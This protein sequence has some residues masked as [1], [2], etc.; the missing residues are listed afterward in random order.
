MPLVPGAVVFMPKESQFLL[1]LRTVKATMEGVQERTTMLGRVAARPGG[2]LD[3]VA[4]QSGRL[5]FPG[6]RV[7]V[8]GE[9]VPAGAAVATLVI[10]DSLAIRAPIGG[11]VTGVYASQRQLVQSGQ[12]IMSIL[13][14]SID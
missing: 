11:V 9:H 4:P 13:D 8:L 5:L 14:P 10:V 7:P 12:R 2:E 6:G 3:I 1:E